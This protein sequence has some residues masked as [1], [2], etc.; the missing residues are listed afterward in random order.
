M[1]LSYSSLTLFLSTILASLFHQ[2]IFLIHHRHNGFLCGVRA[3][4]YLILWVEH[5]CSLFTAA[6]RRHILFLFLASGLSR[7]AAYLG[8]ASIVH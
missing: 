2:H 1:L 3:V 8:R 4:I 7:P 5:A 6:I